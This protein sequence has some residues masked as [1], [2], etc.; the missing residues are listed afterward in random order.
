MSFEFIVDLVLQAGPVIN[1]HRA[2]LNL[3]LGVHRPLA[4]VNGDRHHHVVALIPVGLG[5]F[6]VVLHIQH[7]H[8]RLPGNHV[9]NP[10]DVR[11]EGTDNPDS[12]NIAEVIDHVGD[13][14]LS[15][16]AFQLFDNAFRRLQSGFNMFNR[17][18]GI[19]VNKFIVQ[20]LD[21]CIDLLQRGVIQK[22]HGLP[23]I[24]LVKALWNIHYER[25]PFTEA[26][27][28]A[29]PNI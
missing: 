7:R 28:L 1:G 21:L 8:V 17:I 13:R 3:H 12:G 23:L 11:S 27:A 19:N 29:E 26:F 4:Q 24:H 18:V 25:P 15:A 10:V 5:I 20:N 22:H 2:D 14:H 9:G 16:V 6:N